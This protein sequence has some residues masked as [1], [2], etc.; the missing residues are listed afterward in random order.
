V[1]WANHEGGRAAARR[2]AG[3]LLE[4]LREEHPRAQV[5]VDGHR[6]RLK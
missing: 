4:E 5:F 1:L 6:I 2:S 3:W